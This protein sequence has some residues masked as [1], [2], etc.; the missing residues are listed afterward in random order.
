MTATIKVFK[1]TDQGAPVLSNGWGDLTD[2]LD[3]CLVNGYN[4]KT[5]DSITL[6][7]STATAAISAG[8]LYRVDQVLL[9][10]GANQTEYNGEHRVTAVTTNTVSFAVAGT[11][12]SPATT[13]SALSCK[14]APLGFDIAFT[15]TNKRAYRSPN[16]L[17]NRPYL[18]VDNSLDPVYTSTAD[19]FGKVTM[20]EGMSD[21]DT[22]VGARAPYDPANPTKNEVGTGSGGAAYAGWYKW[23]Y[24]AIGASNTV[25]TKNWVI[26]GD[27]RGFYFLTHLT[28]T[29]NPTSGTQ[30]RVCYAFGDFSSFKSGDAYNTLL[31]ASD[32]YTRADTG[33][34]YPSDQ[35]RMGQS[36]SYVGNVVLR[37]YSQLGLPVRWGTAGLNLGNTQQNSGNSSSVPFPNGPDFGLLL[38]PL[39]LKQ[40]NTHL[41]GTAPGVLQVCQ[42]KPYPDMTVIT[43]ATGFTGRKILLVSTCMGNNDYGMLA[44]DTS[45]PW[46]R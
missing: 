34:T 17:S 3:A 39:Y 32:F 27:D 44:F 20:A 11:P 45:G 33:F 22:F 28:G 30:N 13:A 26:I 43:N 12:A 24:A 1:S 42:A 46:E 2:M 40:E 37:D 35:C 36:L 31:C 25:Q 15:G 16:I 38:H 41:R 7:G 29:F 21:I 5:I 19:K 10:A 18:R 9:V 8:H 23:Y 4:L 14:I 6:A